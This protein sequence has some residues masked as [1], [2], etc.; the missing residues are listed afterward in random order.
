MRRGRAGPAETAGACAARCTKALRLGDG[1][2][3]RVL[4]RCPRWRPEAIQL[5]QAAWAPVR[6]GARAPRTY[7]EPPRHQD[8]ADT[9]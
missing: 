5:Y 6:S 3:E 4:R 7:R 2:A 9:R 8:E 1:E